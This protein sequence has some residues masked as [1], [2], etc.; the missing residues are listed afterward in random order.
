MKMGLFTAT[1]EKYS[2]SAEGS[3]LGTDKITWHS[4]GRLYDEVF[5]EL[6]GKSEVSICELGVC[7][8][9]FTQAMSEYLPDAE[10]IGIDVDLTNIKFGKDNPNIQYKE[11]DCTI[12]T[13]PDTLGTQFDLIID[14]A[15]HDPQDQKT[16]LDIFAPYLKQGGLYIIEDIMNTNVEN[17]KREFQSIADA[18]HLKMQW[19]DLTY[20][21]Q[22]QDD[23]LCIFRNQ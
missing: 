14:D 3:T 9:G 6:V 21:K 8:G 7:S 4:Y 5:T 11:M 17:K 20:M 12:A 1:I 18:H 16:T 2:S 22:K 13:T 10:I 19:I 15:S 23:I